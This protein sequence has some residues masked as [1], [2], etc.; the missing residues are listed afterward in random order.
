VMERGLS[1]R[2]VRNGFPGVDVGVN[3][4]LTFLTTLLIL[5]LG[6]GTHVVMGSGGTPGLFFAHRELSPGEGVGVRLENSCPRLQ[7]PLWGGVGVHRAA[8]GTRLPFTWT[9]VAGCEGR[10]QGLSET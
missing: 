9:A 7:V 10:N 6:C 4:G 8:G 3:V 2:G 1:E 5:G